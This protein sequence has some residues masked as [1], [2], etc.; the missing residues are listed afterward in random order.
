M[1]AGETFRV[2][3]VTDL[4][5]IPHSVG[6]GNYA[7]TAKRDHTFDG[8]YTVNGSSAIFSSSIG[9]AVRFTAF[10]DPDTGG[11]DVVGD[12]VIDP[13]TLV[14]DKLQR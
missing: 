9:S 2:D 7:V 13:L 5:A 4:A 10:D 14:S 12:G 1:A 11:D 6:P 3:F 8:H